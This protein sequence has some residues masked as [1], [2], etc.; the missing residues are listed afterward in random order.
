MP[1]PLKAIHASY[2]LLIWA[3]DHDQAPNDIRRSLEL[4]RTCDSDLQHLI[5]LRNDCLPLLERRPKVL[6]RVHSIIESAQKG[7]QEVCEIV[8]R[9]R[10]EADRGGKTT[11][12]KRM[13]WL[14][15]DSS[16]FR[17]QEPIVSRHHAAVLAELNFLRQIALLAPVPEPEKVQ[18]KLGVQEDAKVFD[19]V[20]LLGD[21]FGDLTSESESSTRG[22]AL[23]VF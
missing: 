1:N 16:E 21:I 5:E 22:A 2:H 17:S 19:S 3:L 4:V 7:L 11:F 9:C 10:P 20:A 14:L 18:E 23:L 8:E 13:A 12:S 6:Q 15:V